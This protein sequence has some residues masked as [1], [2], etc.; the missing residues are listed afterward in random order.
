MRRAVVAVVGR[1]NVGKSTL[2]NYLAGRRIS[3]VD[4]EPGITRDRISCPV[5]WLDRRFDLIDTGGIEPSTDSEIL[6]QMREQA[7]IA[8]EMADVILFM[9]DLKNGVQAA[10]EEIADFLHRSGKPV[11]VA[12]NKA[13]TPGET[14]AEFY[15]FYRFGFE[16]VHAISAEHG[17]GIGNMLDA[18]AAHFPDAAEQEVQDEDLVR[19]AIIGKPNVGKSSLLNRLFG[20]ERAIVSPMAG[21]TRDALETLIENEDGKF[22]FVDTAGLRRKSKI[23]D[24]IEHYSIL[25][26]ISAIDHADV[27]LH[28][29]DATEGP[30]EQDTKIAG[31]AHEAGK[32]LIF[33][34]NKWDIAD[35]DETPMKEMTLRVQEAFAFAS[36]A[37]VLFM[38]A[39]TGWRCD[40]LYPMI[41]QVYDAACRRV[42][43]ALLNEIMAEAQSRMQSQQTKGKQLR[44][45]YA[46]QVSVRPPTFVLFCKH[47][48]LMHFSYK[49]YIEN[50]LRR[51]IDLL[52]TPIRLIL[53]EKKQDDTLGQNTARRPKRS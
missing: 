40:R 22:L 2:F 53:R 26:A 37:P 21:T 19:V 51:E 32:A 42:P 44:I 16:E 50:T 52:G 7:Y 15:D 23:S 8:V 11:V 45:R 4:D 35:R 43:T 14:P 39:K 5:T 47:H 41:Q 25:R 18:L 49:R 29:I 33:V 48:E 20:S 27:C 1:P 38:S 28:L 12:V 3:I 13:D 17:L 6:K 36:Y 30:S 31:L 10:D 34:V 46:T 9:A 24:R